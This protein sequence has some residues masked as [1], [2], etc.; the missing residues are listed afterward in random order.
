[1]YLLFRKTIFFKYIEIE[2]ETYNS[3]T[4]INVL[5]VTKG[6]RKGIYDKNQQ[7]KRFYTRGTL[8][9]IRILR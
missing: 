7:Q 1:M 6:L 4:L 5:F 3:L 8:T 9:S 2:T